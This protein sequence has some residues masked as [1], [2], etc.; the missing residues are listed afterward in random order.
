MVPQ[1]PKHQPSLQMLQVRVNPRTQHEELI[2][3]A[4]YCNNVL[5]AMNPHR[6]DLV[7]WEWF[8]ESGLSAKPG[9]GDLLALPTPRQRAGADMIG[10]KW[11][12]LHG[13][14]PTQ[15][16]SKHANSI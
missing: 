2:V 8:V 7:T 13:G 14:S 1:L 11:L 5:A 10:K 6:L 3:L 4:G 15:V 16:R 9:P 12:L